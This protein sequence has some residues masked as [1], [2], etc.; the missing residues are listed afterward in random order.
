MKILSKLRKRIGVNSNN[1]NK[2]QS[3]IKNSRINHNGK[4]I[5]KIIYIYM[6]L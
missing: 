4:N 5:L 2:T 6:S 3:E 1:F